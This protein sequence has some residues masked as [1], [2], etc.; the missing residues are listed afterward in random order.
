MVRE[1]E[2][3]DVTVDVV[4]KDIKN[5]HLSVY[6][7]TGRV[8]VS[9]PSDMKLET[10]RLFA[11]SKIGWIRKNQRKIVS[12]ERETPR[13]F[14]ERES[15]YIWGRRYLLR[16]EDHYDRADVLLGHKTIE[17]NVPKESSQ[18]EKREV[19]LNWCREELRTASKPIIEQY[20]RQLGVQV[21]RLFIQR[22]R[23]KWGSSSPQRQSIRLN[24]DLIR[25]TPDCLRYVILHEMAHFI[26]P[27]HNEHFISILDAN[28]PAWRT[29][30]AT[31]NYGPLS[32]F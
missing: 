31:L 16:I 32:E 23:T 1:L 22:M 3:A 26:V 4:F 24:L 30:R 28:M 29:I 9:A 14:I 11:L 8:R 12:Q 2:I 6:P 17:L 10:V 18:D 21:K 19:F 5:V 7:P 27:S 15:H 20:E 25:F 13:E